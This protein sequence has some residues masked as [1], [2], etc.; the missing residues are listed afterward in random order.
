MSDTIYAIANFLESADDAIHTYTESSTKNAWDVA[1]KKK[2]GNVIPELTINTKPLDT[3][4]SIAEGLSADAKEAA[5]FYGTKNVVKYFGENPIAVPLRSFKPTGDLQIHCTPLTTF[6]RDIREF[7][8]NISN[9][10]KNE[11]DI[12][13]WFNNPNTLVKYKT[14]ICNNNVNIYRNSKDLLKGDTP[15][16]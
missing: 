10:K 5:D 12:I 14:K 13:S 3:M 2:T 1:L 4:V 8:D 7:L 16:D 9:G 11:K 15:A 6:T